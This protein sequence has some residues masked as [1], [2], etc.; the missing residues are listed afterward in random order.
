MEIN[1]NL[2]ISTEKE[3]LLANIIIRDEG[4]GI[5][6]DNRAE[7]FETV[8]SESKGRNKIGLA[9]TR[10]IIELH[11]GQVKF[12][13]KLNEGTTFTFSMPIVKDAELM[14]RFDHSPFVNDDA[15]DFK[16]DEDTNSDTNTE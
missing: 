10:R 11:N 2:Y 4:T 3:G 12:L 5:A 1:G 13:S 16:F 14:P 9:I 8:F 7:I 15:D 6:A